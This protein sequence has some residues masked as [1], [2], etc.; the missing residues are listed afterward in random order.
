MSVIKLRK[1]IVKLT[2]L[3]YISS[4]LGWDQQ[5]NMPD[6]STQ[7]RSEQ[8][9]L[10][11]SIYHK[12]L[13]S[14]KTGD[15][16]KSVEKESDLGLIEYALLREAKR[17]YERAIKIP[18]EL[19][20]EIA[21]T[22]SLGHQA[23]EEAKRKSKFDIFKPYLEK[24]ITLQKQYADK[25][26]KGPTRYDSLLDKFEPGATSSWISQIFNELK[27]TLIKMVKKIASSQEVPD[28]SV[29]KKHYPPEKQ[30]KFSVEVLKKL[31]FDF[32][33]G[34][35]D[36]STHPF[37]T[38]LSSRDVRITTKTVE[39]FL[40]PCI[41]GTIHECG[42]ALY[43]MGFMKEI[44]DTFLADGASLGIHES[45]SRL[46]ENIVGRSEDFW[47]YW[48]PILQKYFP[49]NLKDTSVR[50]F[51]RAIN[52]VQPSFIR[53]EADELTYGLHIILRFDLERKLINEDISTSDLPQIWNSKM[54]E[55]F[56]IEPPNDAQGVLQDVHWSGGLFG[57]FPTYTLGNLYAS[58]IYN[59]AIE[60]YDSLPEMF[61]E[62]DFS[63][64]HEFL[65]E[66]IF[67]YGRIFRPRELIMKVTGEDLNPNYFI[68]YVKNKF[69]SI[70][71]L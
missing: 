2:R 40:P 69:Y 57:Y 6:G 70:Y 66:N 20:V 4:L 36:K 39:N 17:E 55:L 47:R 43:E 27:P 26:D 25:I 13:I 5:V 34:R 44:E 37:T 28:Q 7:G 68:N 12:K 16:I 35:Q 62:G 8:I 53:I 30:F 24:M 51:Y 15:L 64:L 48:F 9:A 49:R 29:L 21:K 19:I 54:V 59:K 11:E 45:Q 46:W 65:K 22:A 3:R 52:V 38:S 14:R 23:W 50:D 18:K 42:H 32:N 10:M 71:N 33:I 58:Q 56:Q 67:Q 63:Q 60:I 31:Q 1:R 41:F 61:R